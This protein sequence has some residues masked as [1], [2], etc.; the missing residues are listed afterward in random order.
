MQE[1]FEKEML[2]RS[3]ELMNFQAKFLEIE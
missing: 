3:S 2:G 1:D